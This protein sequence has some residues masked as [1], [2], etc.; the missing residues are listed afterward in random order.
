M[1]LW[2]HGTILDRP[3]VTF[4]GDIRRDDGNPSRAN[5]KQALGR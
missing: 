5:I 4:Y 1:A 3:I 2:I